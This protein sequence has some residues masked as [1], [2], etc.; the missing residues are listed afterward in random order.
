MAK[1]VDLNTTHQGIS[2]RLEDFELFGPNLLADVPFEFGFSFS[3]NNR[4]IQKSDIEAL[5]QSLVENYNLIE[6]V[7]EGPNC[8]FVLFGTT[9]AHKEIIRQGYDNTDKEKLKSKKRTILIV[10]S[11]GVL[12]IIMILANGNDFEGTFLLFFQISTLII[13]SVIY[14]I[15]HNR[16]LKKDKQTDVLANYHLGKYLTTNLF[17]PEVFVLPLLLLIGY[18]CQY[19]TSFNIAEWALQCS[20]GNELQLRS[21]FTASFVQS[22]EINL[23]ITML[24]ATLISAYILKIIKLQYLLIVFIISATIGNLAYNFLGTDLMFGAVAGIAGLLGYLFL[25]QLRFEKK[26]KFIISIIWIIASIFWLAILLYF[27]QWREYSQ[28]LISFWCGAILGLIIPIINIKRFELS[29]SKDDD[30]N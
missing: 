14:I 1:A 26:R 7:K 22:N 8:D 10:G 19:I 23:I 6:Y 25:G 13:S 17:R 18:L 21:T 15:L 5:K 29:K 2:K 30:T 11:I 27:E 24:V 3:G 12:F 9:D 20:Y 16:D 28:Y 4:A